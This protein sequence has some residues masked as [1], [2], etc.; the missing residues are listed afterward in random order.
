MIP[1]INFYNYEVSSIFKSS[2]TVSIITKS[3]GAVFNIEPGTSGVT[4]PC[5]TC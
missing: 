5:N 2:A 3:P 4:G 1:I